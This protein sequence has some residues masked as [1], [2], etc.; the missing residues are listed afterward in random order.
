[1]DIRE[2]AEEILWD[3]VSD[4]V[5]KVEAFRNMVGRISYIDHRIVEA[6]EWCEVFDTEEINATIIEESGKRIC[7]EFEMPFIMSCWEAKQQLFRVT[8]CAKGKAVLENEE[9]MEIYGV[10]YD[11]VEVDSVYA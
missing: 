1:M 2:I 3:K 8:A 11:D 6:V 4:Y 9:V 7:I 10:M 5:E